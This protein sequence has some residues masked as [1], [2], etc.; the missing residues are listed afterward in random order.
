MVWSEGMAWLNPPPVAQNLPNGIL[1]VVTADQTDFWQRTFY[2]FVHDNGHALLQP[3][4]EEFSAEV[5]F[6]ADYAAQYDQA[7]LMI[8]A[9]S[10]HW[11]KAGIEY[12]GGKAHLAM[13]VTN[14]ASDWS[15]MPLNGFTGVLGLRMTRMGDA[16]WMQ[17]RLQE[18][19]QMFRLAYFPP[20][21]LRA[22]PMCCSPS[23]AGL[24]VKF[25]DMTIG[26]PV[27]RQP[28]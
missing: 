22:G 26:P 16:V 23:R 24:E 4:P 28:Y 15:Q 5:S 7:G 13:V 12:V 17:Y 11:I 10:E 25:W 3:A 21:A 19:W 6:S 20:L 27:S 1:R 8:R 14:G 2:R 9:D 18:A